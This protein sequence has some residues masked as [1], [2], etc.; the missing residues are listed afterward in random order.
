M[1]ADFNS[2]EFD[3]L[4]RNVSEGIDTRLMFTFNDDTSGI[5]IT[6]TTTQQKRTDFVQRPEAKKYII[7]R[8]FLCLKRSQQQLKFISY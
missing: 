5:P 2:R 1:G 4:F 8:E 7:G 6:C 3:K